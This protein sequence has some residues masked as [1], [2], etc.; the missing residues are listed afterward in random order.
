MGDSI[1]LQV[2]L[3]QVSLTAFIFHSLQILFICSFL[4]PSMTRLNLIQI[5]EFALHRHLFGD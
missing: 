1:L 5:D 2:L 4:Q 3:I